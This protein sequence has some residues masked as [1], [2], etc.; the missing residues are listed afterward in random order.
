[1]ILQIQPSLPGTREKALHIIEGDR[2]GQQLLGVAPTWINHRRIDNSE[3]QS[4]AIP[5]HLSVEGWLTVARRS[6]SQLSN[7]AVLATSSCASAS[8]K[9]RDRI[10]WSDS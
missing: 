2:G 9:G 3:I 7:P 6:A 10:S 8:L 5:E 1:V 4:R